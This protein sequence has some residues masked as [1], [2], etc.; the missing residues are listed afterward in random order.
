[1][2]CLDHG[3][4]SLLHFGG[5]TPPALHLKDLH[6]RGLCTYRAFRN[7]VVQRCFYNYGAQSWIPLPPALLDEGGQ[8][9]IA[10]GRD[11]SQRFSQYHHWPSVHEGHGYDHGLCQQS[12]GMQVP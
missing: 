9:R 3:E 2:R 11:R 12:C 6:P 4:L 10:D 5:K 1:M 8:H 7:L